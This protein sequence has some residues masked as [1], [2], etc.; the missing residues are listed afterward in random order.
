MEARY[1]FSRPRNGEVLI[2][3]SSGNYKEWGWE[4]IREHLVPPAVRDNLRSA[5]VWAS[6]QDRRDRIISNPTEHHLHE[7]LIE[8]LKQV[9]LRFYPGRDWGQL[10]GEER[11][12]RRHLIWFLLAV[13]LIFLALALTAAGFWR[14]ARQQLRAT[15]SREL[16]LQA[17]SLS[18]TDPDQVAQAGLLSLEAWLNSRSDDALRQIDESLHTLAL[19]RVWSTKISSEPSLV[20]VHENA[21]RV[22][23]VQRDSV[24]VKE[25]SSGRSLGRGVLEM[26]VSTPE[27]R[28]AWKLPERIAGADVGGK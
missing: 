3:I 8:D 18:R 12:Q 20:R 1:W 2:V 9:L 14:S 23:I 27:A 15:R 17:Q 25:L 24:E 28:D 13:S 26:G 4:E 19:S 22:T 21:N 10:R 11:R 6:V 16:L 7:E 5:P